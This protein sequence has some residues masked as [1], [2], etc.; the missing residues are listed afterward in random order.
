MVLSEFRDTLGPDHAEPGRGPSGNFTDADF[1]A[2]IDEVS[3]R[4]AD[5]HIRRVKGNSYLQDLQR[6]NAVAGIVWSG[7]LFV[8]LPRPTTRTGVRPPRV[9]R[10]AL[11]RQ[12]DDPDHA[13][14][15]ATPSSSWTT[16]T[17]RRSRPG[18]RLRQ[19]RLPRAGCPGGD[20]E[21][22]PR[23]RQEPAHLPDGVDSWPR[24][25]RCSGPSAP[26]RKPSTARS[27]QR[28]WATDGTRAARACGARRAT[29]A[30]GG[31]Q[32]V[33]RLHGRRRARPDGARAASFFALL[34]PSGCGKTTTLRMV[35]GLEQPT[36]GRVLIGD[37]DLTGSRPYERPV[38]TVFQ[39][40]ALF[41]HLDVSATSPS[42]PSAGAP[43]TPRRRPPRRSSW[44]R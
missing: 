24:T 26:Q 3:K 4:I 14:T 10:H 29:C 32:G 7:D 33:R 43:R 39:S 28:W 38:N 37:T 44:C 25:P 36:V 23:A 1:E 31:H 42:A 17:S 6:G 2:A 34:G 20:G 27:G 19:L 40:Y 11:E 15:G 35:A 22:R 41:P 18:R 9:R 5:G 21:D 12:H 8:L 13:A 30:R 16:T